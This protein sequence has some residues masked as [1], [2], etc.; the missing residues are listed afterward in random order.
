M[1][2]TNLISQKEIIKIGL[3]GAGEWGKNYIKTIQETDFISLVAI[4]S[5]NQKIKE[6]IPKYCQIFHGKRRSV[7]NKNVK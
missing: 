3:I 1:E 5:K 4:S 7:I 6:I 2:I